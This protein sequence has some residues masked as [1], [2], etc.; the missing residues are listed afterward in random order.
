MTLAPEQRRS[1]AEH[2]DAKERLRFQAEL[3]EAISDSVIFTDLEGRI[4]YWNQGAEV[5]FGYSARE[6]IGQTPAVLYPGG[7]AELLAED[8]E[9][10]MA[11]R[12]FAD[13]WQG[14]RKDGA[15][16]WVDVNTTV[17]HG[18][19]G[20]PIG[21]IGVAKDATRRKQAEEA[22]MKSERRYRLISQATRE[23][24]WE[25]ELATGK[26][27]WSPGA[28]AMLGF[29]PE[30]LDSNGVL[31]PDHVHPDDRL[32]VEEG[33]TKSIA[34]A[35]VFWTDEYRIRRRDGTYASVSDRAYI[36]RED[37]G[38]P[39]RVVGAMADITGRKQAEEH[40]R[41]TDRLEAVG[42]LAGGI[43]HDLNNML[44]S[45]LNSAGFVSRRLAPD[46]TEV[47]EL[48]R[49]TLAAHRSAKLTQ[50][51]LAFARRDMIQPQA[52][53]FNAVVTDAVSLL[54]PLLRRAIDLELELAPGLP[55]VL[56]DKSRM[57]QVVVNLVLNARD[58][59]PHGGRVI[60]ET[61]S[62]TLDQGYMARHAQVNI[63]P[64]RYVMLAVSDT[65]HGMDRE[66]LSHIFEPFYTT[67]PVGQ[68][69]GLG[70]ATVYG[71]VKQAGGLV[72]AYSEPDIGTVIKI[73][74]PAME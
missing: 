11:G 35:G 68:G 5:L 45:I 51:L 53:D 27:T 47:A 65:G 43:A 21:F 56:A 60:L 29:D 50:Q 30:T 40:Y 64:G 62:V 22:L 44:M 58:A 59:M 20:E 41:Q 18:P 67:K 73:Y 6:M 66:T 61:G 28:E 57:D 25:W 26:V 8:L 34:G 39:V 17:A 19:D 36:E 3:L 14:R 13:T 9:A 7:G 1:A 16:V 24:L 31:G 69:T 33:L 55:P 63:N 71:S 15:V 70:L 49:L 2:K 37:G 42:R 23:A 52:T 46:S 38:R 72:W 32:R 4:R 54:R 74:L 12:A 10:I 48:Q